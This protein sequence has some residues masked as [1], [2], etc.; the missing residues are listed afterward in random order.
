LA[1]TLVVLFAFRN[2]RT[3]KQVG[4]WP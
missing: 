3:M 2:I 1:K 4:Q